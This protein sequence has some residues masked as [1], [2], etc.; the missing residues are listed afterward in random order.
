MINSKNCKW[1]R[2]DVCLL[3]YL[4]LKESYKLNTIDLSKQQTLDTDSKAILKINLEI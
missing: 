2:D 4:Y 1:L 3:S